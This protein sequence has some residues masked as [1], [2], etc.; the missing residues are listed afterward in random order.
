MKKYIICHIRNDSVNYL[1]HKPHFFK[2]P[3][4]KRPLIKKSDAICADR[5]ILHHFS[6]LLKALKLKKLSTGDAI[7]SD[8]SVLH[9]G[10]F[11]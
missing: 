4:I 11:C 7:L 1:Y 10:E 5:S 6:R 8:R 2:T 9:H 3:C